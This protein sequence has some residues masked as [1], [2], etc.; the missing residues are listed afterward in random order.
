MWLEPA[1]RILACFLEGPGYK[2]L[3]SWFLSSNLTVALMA[4]PLLSPQILGNDTQNPLL[5]GLPE[6][7]PSPRFALL[8]LLLFFNIDF[9]HQSCTFFI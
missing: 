4:G 8:L 5:S 6:I 2:Y 9:V 1:E 7:S 3:T